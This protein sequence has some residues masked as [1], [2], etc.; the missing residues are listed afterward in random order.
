M[1]VVERSDALH[2]STELA[3]NYKLLE[4]CGEDSVEIMWRRSRA[5]YDMASL[6]S[7]SKQEKE[8]YTRAGVALAE[9]GVKRASS[10]SP[11]TPVEGLCMKWYAILLGEL[12]GFL[13]TK[14]KIA[15]SMIIKENLEGALSR[16]PKDTT[17]HTAIGVWCLTVADISWVERKAAALC[18]A[19]TPLLMFVCCTPHGF[20]SVPTH[21]P[22]VPN[23]CG[24]PNVVR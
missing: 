4:S 14:E 9:A 16:L 10:E 15:N 19:P 17:V 12:G 20:S 18:A 5:N 3:E 2:G 7:I 8:K 22:L 24:M 11:G 23:T 13:S 6:T 21:H 1:S